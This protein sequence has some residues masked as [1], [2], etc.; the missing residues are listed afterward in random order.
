MGEKSA[1]YKEKNKH[2][3]LRVLAIKEK[4]PQFTHAYIERCLLDY[5]VNTVLG[6]TQD[7]H[8]F[9]LFLQEKNPMCSKLEVKDIPHSIIE[10]LTSA[11]IDEYMAYLK[12]SDGDHPH[13]NGT[14]ALAR[15]RASLKS[16]FRYEVDNDLLDTDPTLKASKG[17]RIKE[18]DI[19]RLDSDEVSR[20]I[21]AVSNTELKQ[22]KS[23]DMS[24]HTQ[25]RDTAIITLLLNTGI[26]VSECVGLDLDD[27]NF[28]DNTITIVRKGGKEA[29]LYFG[30][31]VRNTLRDYIKHERPSLIGGYEVSADKDALFLSLKRKR[32]AV[33]S[34]EY[35][36]NKFTR[37]VVPGKNISPHKLRSTYGTALYNAT[38][39]IRLVADVLGHKDI[40]TTIA[41]YAAIDEE[42]RKRAAGFMWRS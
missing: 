13:E 26:R 22:K 23:Q 21:N 42:H 33:R 18:K 1:Y 19:V 40:N 25:L 14:R 38:N 17:Q 6:Y 4:L 16:F 24:K 5:Q 10:A 2:Q 9:F 32:L 34:V 15:K 12:I 29:R 7:L 20:L 36:V 11:D 41:H 31:D 27:V 3:K 35:L 28:D 30:E 8:T 39:D 37:E